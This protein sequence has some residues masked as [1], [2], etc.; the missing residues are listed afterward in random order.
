MICTECVNLL[1]SCCHNQDPEVA[2]EESTKRP[3]AAEQYSEVD[4]GGLLQQNLIFGKC[5]SALKN[6]QTTLDLI[7]TW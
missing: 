5:L 4:Y 3:E 6:E 2:E 1:C 7:Q